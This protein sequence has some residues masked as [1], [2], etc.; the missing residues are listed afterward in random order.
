MCLSAASMPG[1]LAIYTHENLGRLFRTPPS[2][3]FSLIVD[4]RRPPLEDNTVRYYGQYVAVAVARTVEQARA[5]AEAVKVSYD[6]T[7]S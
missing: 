2:A 6:K 1:V 3:G 7:R 5:A 4:E